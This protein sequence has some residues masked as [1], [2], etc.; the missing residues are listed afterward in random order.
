MSGLQCTC[1]G[2]VHDE[3]R[4]CSSCGAD[5]PEAGLRVFQGETYCED[6]MVRCQRCD[7][8]YDPEVDPAITTLGVLCAGCWLN[9][10]PLTRQQQAWLDAFGP[11]TSQLEER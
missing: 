11:S 5:G 1:R 10:R 8:I 3:C 9:K 4:E 6:C 7:A 2:E